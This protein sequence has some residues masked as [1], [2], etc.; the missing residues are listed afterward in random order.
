MAETA[1]TLRSGRPAGPLLVALLGGALLVL[2]VLSLML[3][4][5]ALSP[6]QVLSALVAPAADPP[7]TAIV[8]NL[9][10]PRVLLAGVAGAFV[11][12]A[13]VLLG[14]LTGRPARDP[15]WSGVLALGALGAVILLDRNPA[16]ASWGLALATLAGCGVGVALLVG[17]CRLWPQRPVRITA[18]GLL[19]A[20]LAPALALILLIG[21]VRIATWV[22]WSLGSLEQRDWAS[23]GSVWPLAL[24]AALVVAATSRWPA[25]AALSWI[26]T[27]LAAA[28]AVVAAGA[29]GLVGLLAGRLALRLSEEYRAQ[30]ALAALLGAALLLGADLGAR[31]LTAL[32]PSLGLIGEVPVG[33]VL[34]IISLPGALLVRHRRPQRSER[35]AA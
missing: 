23:W 22:R 31:G 20:C 1:T 28:A 2:A 9:R 8:R 13:A 18:I 11:G 34:G 35:A 5:V 7:A 6:A 30:L 25:R 21:E 12:V 32:L 27:T 3:G 16:S 4:A 17:G 15:G 33:A 19:L 10:L 26:A 14:R 29:V 24:L